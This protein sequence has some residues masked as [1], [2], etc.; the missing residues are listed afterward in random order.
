MG[1]RN[2]ENNRPEFLPQSHQVQEALLRLHVPEYLYQVTASAFKFILAYQ[3]NG[4]NFKS[5][6]D[7]GLRK[8]IESQPEKCSLTPWNNIFETVCTQ[9]IFNIMSDLN[10]NTLLRLHPT[11]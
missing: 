8:A 3:K 6:N 7:L 1:R 4:Y 9:G 5:M 11:Q 2:L 10:N